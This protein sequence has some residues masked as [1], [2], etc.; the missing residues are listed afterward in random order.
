MYDIFKYGYRTWLSVKRIYFFI[1]T[2]IFKKFK[3]GFTRTLN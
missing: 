1:A 2:E 3:S